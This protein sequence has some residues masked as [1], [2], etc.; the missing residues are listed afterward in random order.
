M[1]QLLLEV[2]RE[3]PFEKWDI[4]TTEELPEETKIFSF[5]SL[6]PRIVFIVSILISSCIIYHK[7]AEPPGFVWQ[8]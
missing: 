1:L 8:I 3:F 5:E 2:F 6:N 4:Q 7:L